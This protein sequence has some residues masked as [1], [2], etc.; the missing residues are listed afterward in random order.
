M[1]D[2]S[3][4]FIVNTRRTLASTNH[5]NTSHVL[6]NESHGWFRIMD[7]QFRTQK[8]PDHIGFFSLEIG[9]CFLTSEKYPS[10]ESCDKTVRYSGDDVRIMKIDRNA[11]YFCPK[12]YGNSARSSF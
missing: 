12:H 11:E 3:Y 4:Q 7:E 5:E 2:D 10:R 6:G 9:F 1:G 8:L